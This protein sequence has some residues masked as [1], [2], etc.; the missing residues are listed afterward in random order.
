VKRTKTNGHNKS[1][2]KPRKEYWWEARASVVKTQSPD[3]IQ[4]PIQGRPP[5]FANSEVLWKACTEYFAWCEEHPLLE[6]KV[7]CSNGMIIH[8]NLKKMR[9]MTIQGLCIFLGSAPS[10]WHE[11]KSDRGIEY[12][13]VR[14]IAEAV[15][16]NQKFTGAAA[17][18][19]KES[20][21]ARDL[22]LKDTH[23]LTGP[24]GGPIRT[25]SV[26]VDLEQLSNK[27]MDIVIALAEKLREKK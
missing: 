21:I 1:N 5:K 24:G 2:P 22:G 8:G 14:L 9:A 17:A 16:Y 12:T 6:D 15:I 4:N 11:L 23:E 3:Q 19:L 26:P 25:S 13:L 18:L 27:E 20:I 10:Y 7:F